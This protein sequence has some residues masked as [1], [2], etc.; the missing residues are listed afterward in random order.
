MS[1][2]QK[3]QSNP[4]LI[5][6]LKP[7]LFVILIVGFFIGYN[8]FLI[9]KNMLTLQNVVSDIALADT[10][11]PAAYLGPLLQIELS[12]EISMQDI[13][14]RA[15]FSVQ[16]S[17]Y[18][19][20]RPDSTREN[21]DIVA[22]SKDIAYHH[23]EKRTFILKTCD[24]LLYKVHAL[25]KLILSIFQKTSIKEVDYQQ[26]DMV[27]L[28]ENTGRFKEAI[29]S[30]KNILKESPETAKSPLIM[31]KMGFAYHKNGQFDD[32]YS[33]Y[34]KLTK[35]NPFSN[36][37]R[38]ARVLINKIDQRKRSLKSV[39]EYFKKAK[40]LPD[41]EQ[42]QKILYNAA[43]RQLSSFDIQ[44]A[45]GTL[46]TAEKITTSSIIHNQIQIRLG[47]CYNLLGNQQKAE[48]IFN[49]I[50]SSKAT[51]AIKSKARYQL[52]LIYAAQN[53]KDKAKKMI[54][55]ALVFIKNQ[56]ARPAVLFS[57]ANIFTFD[58]KDKE[59]SKFYFNK[60]IE[61][62]PEDS[63][64]YQTAEIADNYAEVDVM[65]NV[66]S[67]RTDIMGQS[68]G[69][70]VIEKLMPKTMLNAIKRAA[71]RFTKRITE[72]VTEIVVLEEYDVAKGDFV[73]IDL[74]EK[75]LNKYIKKWFP[76]GNATKI[77]DVYSEF[78]GERELTMHGTIHLS[79][80]LKVKGFINGKFVIVK[81]RDKPYWLRG[82]KNRKFTIFLVEECKIF[83]IPLPK[84]IIHIL[85]RPCVVQFNKDF[86]L[87]VDLF[88]LDK[89]HIVFAGP[90]REDIKEEIRAEAYGM[91]YLSQRD[92]ESG[93]I[94]GRR[95]ESLP[96]KE[97]G[98]QTESVATRD[99]DIGGLATEGGF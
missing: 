2:I 9:N 53:K 96:D 57:A 63:L 64:A 17:D 20:S 59:F 58:A 97:S 44:S 28:L 49:A 42:K 88:V 12:N 83:G 25:S 30:Y 74:T 94:Y 76:I 38:I 6:I 71:V 52:A 82:L 75:R 48:D 60:F 68:I 90:I 5:N 13:D 86:P 32:A 89:N 1:S 33:S 80:K 47:W 10:T 92:E 78:E 43:L 66:S 31:L 18:V 61:E 55:E 70:S 21:N 19:V 14:E 62:F 50:T 26:I 98:V 36:E 56:R 99:K 51:E 16:F 67:R 87:D 27:K 73:T 37:A 84:A 29:T 77:W 40:A 34:K 15:L 95:K 69:E 22:M 79:D 46:E 72:G 24:Y 41:S 54:D 4:I 7:I 93:F 65:A 45:L 91:R 23:S 39:E 35:A 81:Q 85:L 3:L 11:G 8:S